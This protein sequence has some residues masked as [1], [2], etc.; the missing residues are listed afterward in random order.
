MLNSLIDE[1]A[2]EVAKALQELFT[3]YEEDKLCN[4][5]VSFNLISGSACLPVQAVS[6]KTGPNI[7]H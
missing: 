3:M 5:Y 2:V 4:F 6:I 1:S 7:F